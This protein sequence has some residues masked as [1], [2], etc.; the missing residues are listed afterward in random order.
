[1]ED[2]QQMEQALLKEMQ[3]DDPLLAPDFDLVTYFNQRYP[4]EKS[5]ENI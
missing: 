3:S 1:M 2:F 4:D 5:L